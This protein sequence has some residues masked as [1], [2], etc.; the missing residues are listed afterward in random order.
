M[1]GI[2]YE[3]GKRYFYGNDVRKDLGKAYWWFKRSADLGNLEAMYMLGEIF[4]LAK[5]STKPLDISWFTREDEVFKDVNRAFQWFN[6]C[7]EHCYYGDG[8]LRERLRFYG[9]GLDLDEKETF[10]FFL[11]AIKLPRREELMYQTGRKYFI[12][13]GG[14]PKDLFE[15]SLW[16]MIAV[17]HGSSAAARTLGEI[18][19][20]GMG[21]RRDIDFAVYW[22]EKADERDYLKAMYKIGKMYLDGKG[23]D[24]NLERACYYFEK[25]F[26]DLKWSVL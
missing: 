10:D 26:Q 15:A 20:K 8:S 4:L 13:D 11:E 22:Y 16:F 12:G 25:V 6:R 3:K 14:K 21:I 18:Y 17:K 24:K 2:Y 9:F 7:H 19:L 23:V 1:D 5:E